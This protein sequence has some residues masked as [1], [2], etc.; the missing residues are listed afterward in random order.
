MLKWDS[1]LLVIFLFNLFTI[2]HILLK[3]DNLVHYP[4]SS[5]F[6][7]Y[8]QKLVTKDS[9]PSSP[10]FVRPAETEMSKER[11]RK[12]VEQHYGNFGMSRY[13]LNIL[14]YL[15]TLWVAPMKLIHALP[16]ESDWELK[17][18]GIYVMY[19]LMWTHEAISE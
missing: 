11:L 18:F 1:L 13:N 19:K 7:S 15:R 14:L 12:Y 17:M 9:P 4:F 3:K 5:T 8:D 10:R 2:F 6:T 16:S